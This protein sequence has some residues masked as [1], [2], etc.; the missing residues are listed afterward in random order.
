ML[1]RVCIR[2][3]DVFGC[4][5]EN[6]EILCKD[7]KYR[8]SCNYRDEFTCPA[9]ISNYATLGFCPDCLYAL[10]QERRRR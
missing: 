1:L 8:N 6:G 7:C 5:D 9:E 10:L 2:C 3:G 4:R